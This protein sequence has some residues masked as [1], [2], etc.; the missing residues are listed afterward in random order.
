L[1]I[2]VL[3]LV[4]TPALIAAAS[5]AGRRWGHAVSGWLV[6]FPWTT[7]P[8]AFFVVLERG[9]SFATAT[10]LGALA[11]TIAEA[12]F[13]LAYAHVARRAPW[14]VALAAATVAFGVVAVALQKP[15]LTIIPAAVAVF[16]AL[17]VALRLMPRAVAA[18]TPPPPPRWDL[19]VR[20][21]IATVLVF[22]ITESAA[23]LGPRWSGTLAAFPLYAAILTVFAHRAGPA[24]AVQVLRGLLWGL[25][26][27]AGFFLV[28]AA[29]IE[30]AGVAAAFVAA[31][32]TAV[33]VQAVSLRLAVRR[34]IGPLRTVRPLDP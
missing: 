11:A 34:R 15:A 1:S 33:T 3:K 30:R 14:P 8:V 12:A 31:S 21:V 4:L 32:A 5:L 7:G 25:F 18:A 19:P 16:V 26:G 28:L 10:A 23:V 2:L 17:A 29:L 22:A 9:T 6:G 20:M 24:P 13:A 27:F